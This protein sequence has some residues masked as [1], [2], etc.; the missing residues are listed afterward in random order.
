[1]RNFWWIDA[2][3]H[4]TFKI[5]AFSYAIPHLAVVRQNLPNNE[6]LNE[7]SMECTLMC[8]VYDEE[9]RC[10]F[11]YWLLLGAFY[12]DINKRIRRQC[13]YNETNDGDAIRD[14]IWCAK[15]ERVC[16]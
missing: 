13:E 11:T 3:Q 7:F 14:A 16:V 2:S 12:R 1:M 6:R 15:S 9:R 4:R 10:V 5:L 8:R